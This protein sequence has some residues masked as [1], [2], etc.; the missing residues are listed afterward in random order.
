MPWI[1]PWRI[2]KIS[3]NDRPFTITI[4]RPVLLLML[5]L[6][7]ASLF[8][9][10]NGDKTALDRQVTTDSE[11]FYI[12]HLRLTGI[13][14]GSGNPE[15]LVD[16]LPL[17]SQELK[18][19]LDP[20]WADPE[21]GQAFPLSVKLHWMDD[22]GVFIAEFVI[23]KG[24]SESR[25]GLILTALGDSADTCRRFFGSLVCETATPPD[26]TVPERTRPEDITIL[27]DPG[28]GGWDSGAVSAGGVTE[29]YYNNL[30]TADIACALKEKG[31]RVVFTREPD[32]NIAL[33]L[34]Q[35]EAL[36]READPDLVIS[37]HH[38]NS[39]DPDFSGFCIYYSHYRP[40]EDLNDIDIMVKDS[41]QIYLAEAILEGRTHIFYLNSEG[42]PDY[43]TSRSSYWSVI[44]LSPNPLARES[45]RAAETIYHVWESAG[46]MKPAFGQ[47]KAADYYITRRI[48]CPGILIEGGFLS[49][50]EDESLVDDPEKRK[51]TAAAIA[52]GVSLYFFPEKE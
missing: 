52:L 2:S 10:G 29:R 24:I 26:Y 36:I 7:P 35:R 18:K 34:P 48:P 19:G 50:P 38:D 32:H 6:F 25:Y 33:E 45:R 15:I 21:N 31:F 44:D 5:L 37:V 51:E 8:A 13:D 1:S 40:L 27:L 39:T 49:C 42:N 4:N 3:L 17:F 30:L 23:G 43:V 28:H 22:P 9:A 20:F 46:I 11:P 16:M 41:Q 14:P 47:A 12:N